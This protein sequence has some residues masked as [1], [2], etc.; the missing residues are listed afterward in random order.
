MTT[1]MILWG[2][3]IAAAI[4]L[5]MITMR[6]WDNRCVRRV[7][8][9]AGLETRPPQLAARPRETTTPTMAELVLIMRRGTYRGESPADL[10]ELIGRQGEISRPLIGSPPDPVLEGRLHNTTISTQGPSW[11]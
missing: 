2:I 9:D 11:E 7:L 1:V 3:S 8:R 10:T 4:I 5:G 6:L